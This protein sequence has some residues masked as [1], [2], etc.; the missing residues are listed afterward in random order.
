MVSKINSYKKLVRSMR[1]MS[2]TIS[3]LTIRFNLDLKQRAEV[4]ELI[5][6]LAKAQFW[7]ITKA[8]EKVREQME[9]K[10]KDIAGIRKMYNIPKLCTL[11]E[12][13]P[14]DAS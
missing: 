13:Q 6:D 14:D 2:E 5:K 9:N 8:T 10:H 11:K 4:E 12:F 3:K 1:T 7:D